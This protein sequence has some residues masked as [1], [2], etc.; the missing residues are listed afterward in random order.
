MTIKS[1]AILE[2]ALYATDLD[3]AK[4]FYRDVVGL[5]LRYEEPGR[6][7]FFRCGPGMLLIFNPKHTAK[8][9][10]K[11]DG[12]EI[13]LHGCSGEGHVAF[14]IEESELEELKT[15]LANQGISIESEVEWPN[16]AR[17]AY[18]RDPAGNSIEWATPN[19]WG[20]E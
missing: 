13:P 3:A 17:S 14:R 19:L 16:G 8:V 18:V 6:H 10:T 1:P 11:V 7:I 5:E 15:H 20:L 4:T 9:A 2:T 12:A